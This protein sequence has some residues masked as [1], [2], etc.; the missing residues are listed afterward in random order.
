MRRPFIAGNWKMHTDRRVARELAGALVRGLAG[1]R[2]DVALCPP[3][4]YLDAVGAVIAGSALALGAQDVHW[5]ASGAYT[6]E[7]APPM[8]VD[9][10]C[11]Y[12]IVGHSERRQHAGEDDAIV[13]KKLR[14]ALAA[15]L[16][17]ILCVGESL[18]QRQA[19]THEAVVASQV[20]GALRLVPADAA[21]K[22]AIAYEPVWAIGT[23]V[24][25]TPDQA[26]AMHAFIRGALA[27]RYDSTWAQGC[28]ILYGGSVKPDNAAGLLSRPDI[29]GA[30]VGGASLETRS[31]CAIVGA[32]PDR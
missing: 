5:E 12:V 26:Q 20:E 13:G 17:P 28:R 27:R 16:R 19:D 22:V 10:G 29:D 7:I 31:F 23:G 11:T 9:V 18:A 4:V 32:L 21:A 30:L 6:G 2:A 14:A 24:V 8:L 25:A 3:T 15:G 1:A